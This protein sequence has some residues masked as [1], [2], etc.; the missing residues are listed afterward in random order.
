[1]SARDFGTQQVATL[2]QNTRLSVCQS[3]DMAYTISMG[4]SF[5][6]RWIDNSGAALHSMVIENC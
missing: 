3:D 1:M 2:A 4:G 5:S 6:Y